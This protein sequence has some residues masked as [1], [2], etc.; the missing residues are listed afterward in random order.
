MLRKQT[1]FAAVAAE[2][3]LKDAR[4]AKV[5]WSQIKRGKIN[6]PATSGAPAGGVDKKTPSKT[7][8]SK[9][10]PAFITDDD[11]PT[12]SKRGRGEKAKGKARFLPKVTD[13]EPEDEHQLQDEFEDHDEAALFNGP[14]KQE[15]KEE[16]GD[17]DAI[18][19]LS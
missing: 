8:P 3:G 4:T 14:I 1:D 9:P 16:T 17:V 12:P 18:D 5:R 6:V 11:S 7:K 10:K 19:N 13:S 2:C 15:D